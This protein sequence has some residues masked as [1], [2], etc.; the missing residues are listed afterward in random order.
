MSLAGH[1]TVAAA[2]RRHPSTRSPVPADRLRERLADVLGL[3]GAR[4]PEVAAGILEVRGRSGLA[5]E[6]FARRA[7]VDVDVLRRAEAGELARDV[8]PGCLRRMVPR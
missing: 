7:G 5:S 3:H 2:R 6:E 1:D 8:L 4:W